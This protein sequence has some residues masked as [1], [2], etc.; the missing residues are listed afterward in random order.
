MKR[1]MQEKGITLIA[2]VV[3]IVVLLILAGVSIAMLTGENGLIGK[4]QD[5]K[6]STRGG[7][8]KEKV[9]LVIAE[10]EAI[11]K[12]TIGNTEKVIKTKEEVI[13][14][15]YKDG[16]LTSDEVEK[17]NYINIIMIG[18]INIDFSKL[19]T[20]GV[21]DISR[22][23]SYV[24]YY[25]D[26]DDDKTV[27]GIIYADLALGTT[28]DK[29]W[30]NATY[31]IP[32][33]DDFKDYHISQANY[34]GIFGIK[35]VLSPSNSGNDRFYVM[36]L[37]DFGTGSYGWYYSAAN[38]TDYKQTT[39]ADFG[40]GRTNTSNMILRWENGAYGKKDGATFKDIWGLIQKDFE[41][42]WFLTSK[43]EF[44][45]FAGELG[46]DKTNY[47]KYGLKEEYWSS[48]QGATNGVFRMSF[49][50][51][52]IASYALMTSYYVR[53]STTF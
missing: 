40:K 39:S 37:N 30:G 41:N 12:Q 52:N 7:E 8:V 33:I 27:D 13:Q 32:T 46:I 43:S 49:K 29:Q 19:D 31:N 4:A 22:T 44:V 51:Q 35:H 28:E 14:E 26:I 45:A 24:G 3:T 16:K 2:L 36:S 18:D 9:Q 11:E 20:I 42:G 48:T 34:N 38:M 25:V 23:K 1:N 10:N 6:N 17:L 21:K 47:K 5:A 53:L 50:E 15:L